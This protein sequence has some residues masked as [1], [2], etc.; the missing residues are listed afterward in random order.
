MYSGSLTYIAIS[1]TDHERPMYMAGIAGA[2]WVASVLV[3]NVSLLNGRDRGL[4]TVLG[5]VV[6]QS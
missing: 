6:S 2:W 1:T 3:R 5:P 4:G